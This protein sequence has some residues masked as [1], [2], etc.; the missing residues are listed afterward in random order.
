MEVNF[1]E[2]FLFFSKRG[3]WM[4]LSV[5]ERDVYSVGSQ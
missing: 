1:F 5:F 4:Q 3:P 2:I